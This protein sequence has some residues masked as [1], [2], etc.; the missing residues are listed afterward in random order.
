MH[1]CNKT[2]HFKSR[3]MNTCEKTGGGSSNRRPLPQLSLGNSADLRAFWAEVPILRPPAAQ[4]LSIHLVSRPPQPN[5]RRFISLQ[6]TREGRPTQSIIR[7]VAWREHLLRPEP[8]DQSRGPGIHREAALLHAEPVPAARINVQLRRNAGLVPRF[9][10]P[11]GIFRSRNCLVVVGLH[12]KQRR[13]ILG[14]SSV[15]RNKWVDGR[16]EIRTALRAELKRRRRG[17]VAARGE[18]DDADA[19]R[20]EGPFLRA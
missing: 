5:S 20:V 2:R 7:S 10:Q 11:H 1:I 17:D 14:R 12:D 16:G 19:M 3:K 13:S 6:K 9:V 18:A 15:V 4:L 8:V